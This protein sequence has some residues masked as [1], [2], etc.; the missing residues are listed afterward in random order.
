MSAIADE[1]LGADTASWELH[2]RSQDGD[3]AGT[4]DEAIS[5]ELE[6]ASVTAAQILVGVALM[7]ALHEPYPTL[8]YHTIPHR[9]QLSMNSCLN[10]SSNLFSERRVLAQPASRV[11]IRVNVYYAFFVSH[12]LQLPA[13][14][15][16]SA[17]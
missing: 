13:H 16:P 3:A 5:V 9:T 1:L 2:S 17:E 7:L 8:P 4:A 11:K 6:A 12:E 14:S 15:R 10:K